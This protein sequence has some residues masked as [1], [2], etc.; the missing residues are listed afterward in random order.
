ML[1]IF[2]IKTRDTNPRVV[3]NWIPWEITPIVQI[4]DLAESF[5]ENYAY[6][7]HRASYL[8]EMSGQQVRFNQINE[9]GG[10]YVDPPEEIG[11]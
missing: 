11:R 8:A 6:S 10:F 9:S 7:H 4:L 5:E 3:N 2:K 1:W